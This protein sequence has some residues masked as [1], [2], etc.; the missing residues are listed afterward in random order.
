[1]DAD[2]SVRLLVP[3]DVQVTIV[4]GSED[5]L[6]LQFAP[7]NHHERRL[8]DLPA[9]TEIGGFFCFDYVG[10]DSFRAEM[11][12]PWANHWPSQVD[13]KEILLDISRRG[14]PSKHGQ[15]RSSIQAADG[16]VYTQRNIGIGNT[17]RDSSVLVNQTEQEIVR[18]QRTLPKDPIPSQPVPSHQSQ[19][20][21]SQQSAP[22]YSQLH[23]ST[24][25]TRLDYAGQDQN[26]P[27]VVQTN[28][29]SY[30]PSLVDPQELARESSPA[31]P[32]PSRPA[33]N[34]N[35]QVNVSQDGNGSVHGHPWDTD[36]ENPFKS[37]LQPSP[38]T[39]PDN[40][41]ANLLNNLK[42]LE[43]EINRIQS[44]GTVL[45][46]DERYLNEVYN[47]LSEVRSRLSLAEPSP[48]GRGTQPSTHWDSNQ[49]KTFG[50]ADA[51][52]PESVQDPLSTPP[53]RPAP[54]LSRA[55]GG[56]IYEQLL[57]KTKLTK[58]FPIPSARPAQPPANTFYHKQMAS[59]KLADKRLQ[60]HRDLLAR[61]EL[62]LCTFKPNIKKKPVTKSS[63][64][65]YERNM[66]WMAARD[67]HCL[68]VKAKLEEEELAEC[69]QQF[70]S[71]P[72]PAMYGIDHPQGAYHTHCCLE[73]PHRCSSHPEHLYLPQHSKTMDHSQRRNSTHKP[74]WTRDD[75]SQV[76]TVIDDLRQYVTHL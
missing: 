43:I 74:S 65:F 57:S 38:S 63:G 5:H 68:E 73:N 7:S 2:D 6:K 33:R 32:Y 56:S 1:M 47:R 54:P 18:S 30:R 35:P 3:A 44:K 66:R 29:N 62:K 60:Q 4:S 42:L 58:E 52:S 41:K 37:T 39:P 40:N 9:N 55:L 28:T 11:L 49:N 16:R 10:S 64:D 20:Q 26:D 23:P 70:V 67:L 24:Q 31:Q 76:Q 46:E 51:Y 53:H 72:L 14:T 21:P 45:Q 13:N 69:S 48:D 25:E 8:G 27:P 50:M 19:H 34:P 71:S 59:K 36:S 22:T 17:S 61:E 12:S 15:S 75:F